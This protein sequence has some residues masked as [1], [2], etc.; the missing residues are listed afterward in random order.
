MQPAVIRSRAGTLS[1]PPAAVDT[2]HRDGG[3]SHTLA[4]AQTKEPLSHL[5]GQCAQVSRQNTR[6]QRRA[7][8]TSP[9]IGEAVLWWPVLLGPQITVPAWTWSPAPADFSGQMS[10]ADTWPQLTCG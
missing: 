9:C 10:A 2:L 4:T 8:P 5:P 1:A 7:N 6:A 3:D